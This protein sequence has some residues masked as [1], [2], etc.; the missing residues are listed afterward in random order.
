[1]PKPAAKATTKSVDVALSTKVSDAAVKK[2]TGRD[3]AAWVA[4]LSK[5]GAADLTHKQIAEHL[6]ENERIEPWWAQMVTVGYEQATGRR[7]R[8]EKPDGFSVSG[9]KTIAVPVEKAFAAFATARGRGRWLD[10]D[11]AVRKATPSKSVRITWN[12]GTG[13]RGEAGTSVEVNLYEKPAGKDGLPRSS[14]QVQHNKLPDAKAAEAVK[15][16][17][18]ERL[19]VLKSELEA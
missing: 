2:A 3:W 9:S 4:R 1:M 17:W 5:A 8:H 6:S 13:V 19:G 14:V 10:A 11:L 18:K 7:A 16:W 15:A 12:S